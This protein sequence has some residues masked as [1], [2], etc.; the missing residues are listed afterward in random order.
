MSEMRRLSGE[1]PN[2]IVQMIEEYSR[3]IHRKPDHGIMM[4][5]LFDIIK[6]PLIKKFI[7]L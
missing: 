5:N 3:P 1:L 7:M 4:T 6:R 2:E